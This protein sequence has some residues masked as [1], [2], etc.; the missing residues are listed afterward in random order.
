[1]DSS[2]IGVDVMRIRLP[3]HDKDLH[4]FID[5]IADTLTPQE[6]R[7][8]LELAKSIPAEEGLRKV[9][10]IWTL[11]EAYTKAIGF[12]LGFDFKR[13]EYDVLENRLTVDG[14]VPHGWEFV[15]FELDRPSER[16]QIAVARFTGSEEEAHV[17]LRGL[18]NEGR[19]LVEFDAASLIRPVAEKK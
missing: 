7:T 14:R 9:F 16:Y 5:S 10:L 11:K 2:N 6:R 3:R 19:W 8:L 17:D 13:I 1:M 4:T 15:A 12:G 18:V